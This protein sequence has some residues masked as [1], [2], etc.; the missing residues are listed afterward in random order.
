ML[1]SKCF[2]I[3]TS[4]LNIIANTDLTQGKVFDWWKKA[5]HSCLVQDMQCLKYNISARHA[6]LRSHE[7]QEYRDSCRNATGKSGQLAQLRINNLASWDVRRNSALYE[8]EFLPTSSSA[9]RHCLESSLG[10]YQTHNKSTCLPPT[11][12]TK[13]CSLQCDQPE[14]LSYT[15]QSKR[16]WRKKLISETTDPEWSP[17]Q[18]SNL[19][20]RPPRSGKHDHLHQSKNFQS[21]RTLCA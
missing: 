2:Q 5:R 12:A 3:L 4:H 11:S 17:S 18:I 16:R 1:R 8:R 10:S 13:I 20:N 14:A 15:I 21:D 7:K 9:M 19:P 6:S